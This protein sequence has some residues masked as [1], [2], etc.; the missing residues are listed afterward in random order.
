LSLPRLVLL[1]LL[2][3]PPRALLVSRD[4]CRV[5]CDDCGAGASRRCAPD[6]PRADWLPPLLPAL[7]PPWRSEVGGAER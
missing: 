1:L 3:L 5:D 2:P 4:D 6:E 7:P